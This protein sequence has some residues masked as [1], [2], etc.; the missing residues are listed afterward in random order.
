MIR[1]PSELIINTKKA[2]F[3]DIQHIFYDNPECF[4]KHKADGEDMVIAAFLL[5]EI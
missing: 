4:G 5:H 1:V 2:Y 3:S